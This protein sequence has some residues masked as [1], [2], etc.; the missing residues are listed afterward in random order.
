PLCLYL[1]LFFVHFAH[2]NFHSCKFAF[3]RHFPPLFAAYAP[4]RLFVKNTCHNLFF[5]V[6]LFRLVSF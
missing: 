3:E 1:S 6:S 2:F 4:R 5:D